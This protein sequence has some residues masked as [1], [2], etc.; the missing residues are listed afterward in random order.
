MCSLGVVTW[1]PGEKERKNESKVGGQQG[2]NR[3]FDQPVGWLPHQTCYGPSPP[4]PRSNSPCKLRM[5]YAPYAPISLL[6]NGWI[7]SEFHTSLS[8]NYPPL[9]RGKHSFEVNR[10]LYVSVAFE[11]TPSLLSVTSRAKILSYIF[12]EEE[13]TTHRFSY[14]Y[15]LFSFSL[16]YVSSNEFLTYTWLTYNP[17]GAWWGCGGVVTPMT[18]PSFIKNNWSFKVFSVESSVALIAVETLDRVRC[19]YVVFA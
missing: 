16:L 3:S 1:Q 8:D 17:N 10:P 12:E 9:V 5:L 4:H 13:E 6:T 7:V 2:L 11:P 15:S 14:F 18:I 19:S